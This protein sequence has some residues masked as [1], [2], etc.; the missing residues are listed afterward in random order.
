LR[1]RIGPGSKRGTTAPPAWGAVVVLAV[2][3]LCAPPA[4]TPAAAQAPNTYYI[5]GGLDLAHFSDNYGNGNGQWLVFI[6]SQPANYNLRFDLS[7]AQ[8]WGDRGVGGG[9]SFSKY[10]DRLTLAAGASG[11]SGDFIYPEYRLEAS[12]GYG[13]LPQGNLLVMLGY[14]H[15]QSKV[16]N[17]FDRVALSANWYMDSHWIF[18]G[19]FNYDIGQPG[20]TVT[21]SL[22]LGAT[23]FTWKKRYIGGTVT[24]GD[25]N[26][27]QVSL[28]GFLVAY[29]QFSLRANY[30]EYFNPTFGTNVR[31]DFGTNKYYD[32]YGVSVSVFKSW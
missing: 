13:L 29:K 11:G 7:R 19:F 9:L 23:W 26:Y 24:Y 27:T 8:R 6:L 28:N 1:A 32:V 20:D 18:G 30:S 16:D 12:V 4:C 15:D 10:L 5:E 3:A 25:V 14:L 31:L 21:M 2:T 22:G 17:Y